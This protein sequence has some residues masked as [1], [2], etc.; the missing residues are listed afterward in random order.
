MRSRAES[1]YDEDF[2]AWSRDQ[3]TALRRL[4]ATRPNADIDFL[5]LVDEVADL[6]KSERDA[7]RSHVR[8]IIEHLLKLE[9][10]KAAEPR[11][12]WLVTVQ[13]ARVALDD[14][15]TRS[16]M[17]DARANL[18]KLYAQARATAALE[19]ELHDEPDAARAL[20]EACPWGLERMLNRRERA[21]ERR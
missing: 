20:P 18:P 7:V 4:A 1:L 19:L 15:L 13:K 9:Y 5:H 8:T 16:L 10:A 17:R 6:G 3:A 14:K 2:Y 12:G 21:H 11:A